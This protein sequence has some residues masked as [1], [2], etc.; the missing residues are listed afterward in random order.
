MPL[1]LLLVF[2]QLVL[3]LSSGCLYASDTK[4]QNKSNNSNQY[5]IYNLE[6]RVKIA[7]FVSP[8]AEH[9]GYWE[10]F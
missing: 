2:K 1:L 7:V 5:V 4:L 8:L 3:K 9:E 10:C 6:A